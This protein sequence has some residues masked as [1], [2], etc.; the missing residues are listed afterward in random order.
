MAEQQRSWSFN[1]PVLLRKRRQASSLLVWSGVAATAGG[2]LWMV[3]APLQETIAVQGKLQPIGQVRVI[4]APAAGVVEQVLVR[5]GA[6]VTPGQLLVQMDLRQARQQLDSGRSVLER[7][8]NENRIYQAALG[9]EPAAGLTANQ[10]LALQKQ[11]ELLIGRREASA[12]ELLRARTRVASLERSLKASDEIARRYRS[13]VGSGA[14][15]AVALIDVQERADQQ[16]SDLQE[17]Q[18][19]LKRVEA[20]GN[21]GEAS[22][23]LELRNRIEA[24]LRQI[25]ALQQQVSDAKRL[26]SLSQ[27][28]APVAGVAFDVAVTPGAVLADSAKPILKVVPQQQLQARVYLPNAA[29]GFVQPGQKAL[30][31]L[32]SF[33]AAD[34]GRIG[35]K[36]VA[37]GSD[38][39][40]P[41]QQREVLGT[42]VRGLYFPATLQ[43]DRQSLQA[44]RR[45]IPLTAGMSLTADLQLRERRFISLF[46]AF[47]DDKLKSLERMR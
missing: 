16:R 27:L 28:R 33:P 12:Q 9:E 29:I 20:M 11:R 47:F 46:T 2:V 41:E 32:D 36:V 14:L 24:N 3:V 7:L 34:Y 39:L 30:V 6:E 8:Q 21:A 13:L 19:E 44:G 15:S 26:I 17:A 43:L 31:S 37:V 1:Q 10:R 22:G 25:A 5:D 38:A 45:S 40:P 35:A 4:R 18:A 42:E 23:E